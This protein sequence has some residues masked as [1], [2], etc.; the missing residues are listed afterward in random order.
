V[1]ARPL[2]EA[3]SSSDAVRVEAVLR[4]I[5]GPLVHQLQPVVKFARKTRHRAFQDSKSQRIQ[6]HPSRHPH[7]S[8][9]AGLDGPMTDV[10]DDDRSNGY[11]RI[12]D[13]SNGY[14]RIARA[15]ACAYKLGDKSTPIIKGTPIYVVSGTMR[16][17]RHSLEVT[18]ENFAD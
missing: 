10:P 14:L 18:N 3:D 1:R 12:D 6:R 9:A 15:C 8:Y 7:H 16:H 17:M 11:L 5:V 2:T 13:R 4:R